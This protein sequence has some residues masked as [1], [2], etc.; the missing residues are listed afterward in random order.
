M[1]LASAPPELWVLGIC[2]PLV[3][4]LLFNV[5]ILACIIR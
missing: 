1:I 4:F 3:M 2:T 5:L